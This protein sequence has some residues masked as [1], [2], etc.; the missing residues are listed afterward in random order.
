MNK[1]L[2][3][4]VCLSKFSTVVIRA[5]RVLNNAV[6]NNAVSNVYAPE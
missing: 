5:K 2:Q 6:S 1:V 4:A 3:N